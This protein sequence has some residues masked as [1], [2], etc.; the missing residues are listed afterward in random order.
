M[1][2]SAR[3]VYKVASSLGH[4]VS[5]VL[6]VVSE[7]QVIR[8]DAGSVVAMMEDVFPRRDRTERE[9]VGVTMSGPLFASHTEG[10]VSVAADSA[11]PAPTAVR[12]CD[13]RPEDGHRV[14]C[15]VAFAIALL[16]AKAAL[17]KRN[18]SELT[19]ALFACVEHNIMI[20]QADIAFKSKV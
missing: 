1:R 7:K 5:D 17:L 20:P 9:G 18:I 2:L 12:F 19:S 13:I 3:A 8:T 14:W 15:F 10:S 16:R 11:S 6:Q 4:S